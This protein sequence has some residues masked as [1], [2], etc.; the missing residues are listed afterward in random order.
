MFVRNSVK[1][2]PYNR[3]RGALCSFRGLK[4][5]FGSFWGVPQWEL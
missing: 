4:S 5:G 3:D 1:G 2:I